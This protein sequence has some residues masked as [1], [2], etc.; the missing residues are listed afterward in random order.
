MSAHSS[1]EYFYRRTADGASSWVAKQDRCRPLYGEQSW[2]KLIPCS[3]SITIRLPLRA[4]YLSFVIDGRH[5]HFANKAA[6]NATADCYF[7]KNCRLC[8]QEALF[9]FGATA[10]P[11]HQ[12]AR[13]SSFTK[14]L[15]HTQ[16]RTTVGRTPLDE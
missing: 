11:P 7:D 15:D 13:T 6:Y 5:K 16:R 4:V 8:T 14:F 3:Q 2:M 12:W 10:P 1:T 9:A